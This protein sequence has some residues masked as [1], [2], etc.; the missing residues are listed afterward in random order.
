MDGTI[1]LA[2]IVAGLAFLGALAITLGVD[3]RPD[4]TDELTRS[5]ALS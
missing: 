3:S 2:I 5:S 1:L 4:F